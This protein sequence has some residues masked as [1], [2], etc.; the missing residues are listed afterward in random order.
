[1]GSRT[2]EAQQAGLAAGTS[3]R[4]LHGAAAGT[5]QAGKREGK[6]LLDGTRAPVSGAMMAAVK[7]EAPMVTGMAQR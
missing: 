1:M 5:W 6:A 2:R 4:D 7:R 3:S